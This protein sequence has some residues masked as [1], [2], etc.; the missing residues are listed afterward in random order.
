[1]IVLN[2]VTKFYGDV[3]AVNRVSLE[4]PAMSSTV[5][6]GP[7]GTGKTTLLRLIAGLE[8]PDS[9]EIYIDGVLASR[10]GWA[11]APYRRGLGF[12]FQTSALW[13]HM[14]VAQNILFGLHGIPSSEAS[15]RLHELLENTSLTGLERRYPHQIS[16]G[17]ARRVAL[18]RT[19]AP[20][21]RALLMDEPLTNVDPELK[22]KLLAFIKQSVLDTKACLIYVTHDAGE[23]EQ[24]S[25]RVLTLRDGCL[26]T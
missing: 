19:L 22:L 5:I 14:T 25:G 23:A 3:K 11:M 26:E 16:G 8:I 10:A 17:E 15:R 21:P 4:V 13:P 1:M 7:S 9:G 24:I 20:R 6:L 12:V 18:V 2:Q